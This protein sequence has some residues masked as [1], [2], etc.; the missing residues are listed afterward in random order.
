MTWWLA[1]GNLTFCCECPSSAFI[2]NQWAVRTDRSARLFKFRHLH[3]QKKMMVLK[4]CRIRYIS[5][6]QCYN[7]CSRCC[8]FTMRVSVTVLFS[9]RFSVVKYKVKVIQVFTRIV[10][11][12]VYRNCEM[13]R[14][15]NT[16]SGVMPKLW[17]DSNALNCKGL[18]YRVQFSPLRKN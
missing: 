7:C 12:M 3:S 18:T 13:N 1:D 11:L 16:A 10:C 2:G 9:F 5:M 6:Q 15:M 14:Q 4:S 17:E 8:L